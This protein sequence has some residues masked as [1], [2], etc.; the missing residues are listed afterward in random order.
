MVIIFC[1]NWVWVWEMQKTTAEV[2]LAKR[3]K[4]G[5]GLWMGFFLDRGGSGEMNGPR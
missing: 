5:F 2:R 1:L 4:K 3:E